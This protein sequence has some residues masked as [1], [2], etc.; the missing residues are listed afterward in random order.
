MWLHMFSRLYNYLLWQW[1]HSSL[2]LLI[3]PWVCAPGTHYGC[4]GQ[5]SV[6]YEVCLTFLHMA[7]SGNRTPDP[8]D[9]ESN[10]LSTWPDEKICD[11]HDF[12]ESSWIY[13]NINWAWL[14]GL[15]ELFKY[16]CYLFQQT[17]GVWKPQCRIWE[18]SNMISIFGG[19]QLHDMWR[20]SNLT[21][22][23]SS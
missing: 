1:A 18:H 14:Q 3:Q 19:M 10:T 9:L 6:E 15:S 20:P 5:G 7:S 22:R 13:A 23:F 16:R 8:S 11:I 17:S 4:V 2:Q 21:C 12:R